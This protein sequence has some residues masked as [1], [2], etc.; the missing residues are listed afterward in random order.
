MPYFIVL[1]PMLAFSG[2]VGAM[3][4]LVRGRRR[5]A[6]AFGLVGVGAVVFAI[7]LYYADL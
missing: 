6:L 4:S 5:S 7:T 1:L 3:V 2:V